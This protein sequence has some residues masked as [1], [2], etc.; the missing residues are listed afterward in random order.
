MTMP[1]G[2][3]TVNIDPTT[4]LRDAAGI[5]EYFYYENPPPVLE[6]ADT[7]MHNDMVNAPESILSQPQRLLQPDVFLPAR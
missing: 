3:M 6:M 7:A 4:G 1:P 5:M 2:V